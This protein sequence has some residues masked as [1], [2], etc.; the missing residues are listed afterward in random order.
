MRKVSRNG[1]VVHEKGRVPMQRANKFLVVL[2]LLL[3]TTMGCALTA[4]L[5]GSAADV[6]AT[7]TPVPT[8]PPL[9]RPTYTVQRGD[10]QKVLE[11]TGRWQPR[12]QIGLAFEVE[13]T[14]RRVNVKRGDTVQMGDLLADY[15]T[16][17]LENQLAEARIAY[18]TA[19]QNEQKNSNTNVQTVE[20]AEIALANARLSLENTRNG[21]PWVSSVAAREQLETAQ[22]QLDTAQRNYDEIRSRPDA[23]P[24]AVR[25]AYEAVLSAQEGVNGAQRAIASAGQSFASYQNSVESAENAVLQ[26]ELALERAR[27]NVSVSSPETLRAQR[28]IEQLQAKINKASLFA[29]IDGVVLEVSIKPGDSPKAFKAVITLGKP[30]PHEIVAQLGFNDAQKLSPGMVGVCQVMN[31]PETAVQ[32]AVR[33]IPITSTES[34][35]TTRVA[36]ALDKVTDMVSDQLVQIKMPLEVR[37]NVLWLPPNAIRT[38]QNRTFVVLQTPDGPRSVDVVVGLRT[39]DRVEVVSGVDEGDVVV[40]P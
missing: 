13:G 6:G 11:F 28:N 34:D 25:S 4:P 2:S 20:D 26:A 10:V 23:D 1:G 39:E 5:S 35:Q 37:Q 36:A 27:N 18:Q 31:R 16:T 33:R 29:P 38:Y 32:C 30:E 21:S 3:L 19:L 7:S 12:D 40:A 15:D 14:V 9:T 8:V 24:S 22:R 17:E